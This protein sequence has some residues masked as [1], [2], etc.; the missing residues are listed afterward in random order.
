MEATQTYHIHNA[1]VQPEILFRSTKDYQSFHDK[2]KKYLHP[3]GTVHFIK[4]HQTHFHLIIEFHPLTE[5]RKL[6]Q[7]RF[8]SCK[9]LSRSLANLFN[10]YAQSYNKQYQRKGSLFQKN[11]KQKLIIDKDHL[12]EILDELCQM[13]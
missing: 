11:F 7:T 2:V 6:N 1:S 10:S 5:L 9:I 3:I 8:Q 12:D 13:K 4:L